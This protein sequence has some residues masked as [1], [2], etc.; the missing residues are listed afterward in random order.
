MNFI[1]RLC[2]L[3]NLTNS[4]FIKSNS[5]ISLIVDKR[6]LLLI[7]LH[8]KYS[9][10]FNPASL[11][12]I[13]CIDLLDNKFLL[14]YLFNLNLKFKLEV[15]SILRDSRI[16]SIESIYCNSSWYEREV[17]EMF[18]IKFLNTTDSRNLLLPYNFNGNPMRKNWSNSYG[19][20][21]DSQPNFVI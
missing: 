21:G 12:S 18:G 20:S 6:A 11:Q 13:S 8:L 2:V 15:L 5:Q 7:V 9:L 17:S 1:F 19:F 10:L 14:V 16:S 3:S 4:S